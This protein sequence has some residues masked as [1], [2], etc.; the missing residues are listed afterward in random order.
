MRLAMPSPPPVSPLSWRAPIWIQMA[1]SSHRARHR[2]ARPCCADPDPVVS[3]PP[4]ALAVAA[5]L[6]MNIGPVPT[7]TLRPLTAFSESL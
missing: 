1:A 7:H 4:F 5:S 3:L 2:R 6:A